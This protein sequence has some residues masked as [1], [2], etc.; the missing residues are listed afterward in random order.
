M[1]LAVTAGA[2]SGSGDYSATSLSSAGTWSAGGNSGAFNWALPLRMPPGVGGPVPSVSVGYSSSVVD[3]QM[4]A[5]N[6]QPSWLGEGFGWWPGS[7]ER[8]YQSCGSDIKAGSNN[9][10]R[11]TGDACWNTDNAT[12]SLAGRSG[13]LIRDAGNVNLWHLRDEDGSKVERKFNAGNG[14]KDGEWWVLTDPA[15]VQYWFGGVPASNSTWTMPVYGNDNA[16]GNPDPC[17]TSVFANSS[18]TQAWRWNLDRVVDPHGNTMTYTYVKENNSYGRNLTPTDVVS[19]TRGGYLQTIEY[20]TRNGVASPA[21]ARVEFT[22]ADRCLTNCADHANWPDTPRDQECSASPC[23]IATP[24]FW[25]KHRLDRVATKVWDTALSPAG[26]R[27]VDSWKFT[28]SFPNTGDGTRPGL[29]LAKISHTGGNGTSAVQAPDITFDGVQLGNRVQ[30]QGADLKAMN[31]WRVNV[32]DNGTGG[33]T[34][35]TY[36]PADCVPGTRMPDLAALHDNA[37]R[38]YP[39]TWVQPNATNPTTEFFHKYAVAKVSEEDTFNLSPPTQ[40]TYEYESP[41]WHYTD[42]DGFIDAASKTW[43]VW[44]GYA[45]VRTRTG[46]PSKP[47]VTLSESRFFQGLNGDKM[48]G[49]TRTVTLP[50]VDMNGDGDTT[51]IGVDVPAAD[52][53]D[54]FAGM[55]RQTSTFNGPTGGEVH[56]SIFEPWRSNPTATRSIN[57]TTTEA[58]YTG[59]GAE[60]TRTILDGGRAP[61]S[62]TARTTFDNLGMPAA[63]SD[64]GDNAIVGDER[65]TTTQYARSAGSPIVSNPARVRVFAVNCARAAQP[66]LAEKD[67]IS[68][69]VTLY[70][71]QALGAIGALGEPTQTKTL[72]AWNQTTQL[73]SH[74]TT[75]TNKYDP[76]GR[77]IELID[78][79]DNKSTTTY[80]PA[81]GGPLTSSTETRLFAAGN[82]V[83]TTHRDPGTGAPT[84]VIDPNG[85]RTDYSYDALARRTGVWLPGQDRPSGQ[86]ATTTY[87]YLMQAA[88]PSSATTRTLVAGGT[89]TTST[90]LFDGRLRN[91]QTQVQSPAG[92]RIVR[93]EHYDTAGRHVQTTNPHW[94]P[95]TTPNATLSNADVPEDLPGWTVTTYDGANR[96][97][98]LISYK[99]GGAEQWRTTSSYGGDRVDVTPP[100]GGTATSTRTNAQG[101][102][103]ELR[104]YRGSTPTP[105][106]AGSYDSTTYLFDAKGKRKNVT[107]PAGNQW[108]YE[109]DLHGRPV[110]TTDPDRGATTSTFSE[111]GDLRSQSD[112]RGSTVVYD[113]DSLG[114]KTGLYRTTIAAPNRLAEWTYDGVAKG[115][116]TK[117]VRYDN[118]NA[119]TVEIGAYGT[120]YQPVITKI[121]IPG[122]ETGLTAVAGSPTTYQYV[123]TYNADGSLNTSRIPALGG[124]AME[125]L[126]YGY[127]TVGAPKTLQTNLGTTYV[128][129]TGYTEFGEPG[130]TTLEN[131][132][133]AMAQ[134]GRYYQEGTHRLAE[135]KTTR[136][137]NPATVADVFYSYDPAGNTTKIADTISGDT[138]CFGTDY[139]RRL[140][141]AWTPSSGDCDAA[142]SAGGLGGPAPYWTTWEFQSGNRSK[143]TEN[144]SGRTT[145]YTHP[146][147]GSPRPHA[148]TAAATTVNG[149]TSSLAYEYDEVGSMIKRPGAS[150]RQELAWDPEGRLAKVTE[151]DAGKETTFV[152]DADGNRLIRRDPTGKTLYLPGQE[153]RYTTAGGI[154][155]CARYYAHNGQQVAIRT[156]AG[157]NWLAADQQGTTTVT[158]SGAVGQAAALRRQDP[159]GNARGA[160]VGTWPTAMDKGFVGGTQDATGLTHLGAREYDPLIGRFTSVDPVIDVQSPQQMHGYSYAN[161]S[162]V[163][164]ADPDGRSPDGNGAGHDTAIALRV[165]ELQT[166]YG[167]AASISSDV[168]STHG[169]DLICWNC[170]SISGGPDE[171]WVWEMKPDEPRYL[172]K[173]AVSAQSILN[174]KINAAK[175]PRALGRMVDD[176]PDF[177]TIRVST[178]GMKSSQ[179]VT[180]RDSGTKGLQV[181][182]LH[183]GEKRYS[184]RSTYYKL[185]VQAIDAADD[186]N[187][188][189]DKAL[190]RMY[191]Q[192]MAYMDKLAGDGSWDGAN[193]YMEPPPPKD[194]GAVYED[195]WSTAVV[196]VVIVVAV[197]TVGIAGCILFCTTVAVVALS[198]SAYDLAA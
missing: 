91:L 102:T 95:T 157:L 51:D 55:T 134:V 109:Y 34:A 152:Y 151:I 164:F 175:D 66:G 78:E 50:A 124:L 187:L 14:A 111:F 118:G 84:V 140:T 177:G 4:A 173:S 22:P 103:V 190:A 154:K 52:D 83:T 28:H 5:S 74:R 180:V 76:H 48:P 64:L 41:G 142:P 128:T 7:L 193:S 30:P 133:A 162:P 25:T 198:K 158:I 12:I 170:S 70:D 115:H 42:D 32:I 49:G 181:Y 63:V 6:N 73:A 155:T 150:G 20:G 16:A 46:D 185:A 156:N 144:T 132:G 3:G 72:L 121:T 96:A 131:T 107:D 194:W 29:W 59:V 186:A 35:V 40:T 58:R 1:L 106:I 148:V 129:G 182:K 165:L 174:G 167:P 143:Q 97:T 80:T 184:K 11:K 149:T 136:D 56:S 92:G 99:K 13:E 104:E 114:R 26:Y 15:G 117:S 137:T 116:P 94:D 27:E 21:P 141:K 166:K 123:N 10:G 127:N 98:A 192:K 36:M 57:N 44:R 189:A 178:N 110:A 82:W 139:L 126:T 159:Y 147:P 53:N 135:I 75:A 38:C 45:K 130:I 2:A 69:D 89:Y 68:D 24:T 146:A 43:S 93:D 169:A 60:H 122:A 197:V 37:L 90:A 161:N 101:Q 171:V 188:T 17:Y 195:P 88:A 18:C 54:S 105:T 179:L 160:T 191:E 62:T 172:G 112:A 85:K 77:Q 168:P 153:L 8:R 79:R 176:G 138:Q 125:T 81:S 183:Q 67:I 119:Y 47:G 9:A 71:Q 61:R 108:T 196:D 39:V 145:N 23:Q 33:R 65:C 113:Y 100:F 87:S 120:R 19:Y 31:W 86:P 163:T